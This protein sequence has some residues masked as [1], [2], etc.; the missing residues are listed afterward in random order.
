MEKDIRKNILDYLDSYISFISYFDDEAFM[1]A[2]LKSFTD[3]SSYKHYVIVVPC[4]INDYYTPTEH[5]MFTK[6]GFYQQEVEERYDNRIFVPSQNIDKVL[7]ILKDG[8][9]IVD[10][11]MTSNIPGLVITLYG[12]TKSNFVKDYN[13]WEIVDDYEL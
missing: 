13:Q 7:S 10:K 4:D 11:V 12:V 3:A 2:V 1:H 5:S 8:Q 9:M 6:V